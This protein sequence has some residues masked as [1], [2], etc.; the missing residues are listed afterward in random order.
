MEAGSDQIG[1]AGVGV[2]LHGGLET[3]HTVRFEV[4]AQTAGQIDTDRETNGK[5]DRSNIAGGYGADPYVG[6]ETD[7]RAEVDGERTECTG[8][9]SRNRREIVSTEP[10]ND[11]DPQI[12]GQ[13]G[14]EFPPNRTSSRSVEWLRSSAGK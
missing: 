2:V 6:A 8:S 11:T 13:I 5:L 7:R 10:G 4:S 3:R 12:I 1:E 9:P 14:R